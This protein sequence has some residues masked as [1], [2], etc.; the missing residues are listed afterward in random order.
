M[1]E[2][3]DFTVLTELKSLL[4]SFSSEYRGHKAHFLAPNL[5]KKK[6]YPEKV[7]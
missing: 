4:V 1:Q 2:P 6:N 3:R 5:K 7:S